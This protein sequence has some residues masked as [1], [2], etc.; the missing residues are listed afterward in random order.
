VSSEV[1]S[2]FIERVKEL[3]TTRAV[4]ALLEWDQET[5]MPPRAAQDRARQ[6]ALLAGLAHAQLTSDELGGLLEQLERQGVGDDWAAKTNLR[7]IRREYER[8]VRL[9]R[10]LVEEIARTSTLA[11]NAWVQARKESRFPG[12]APHLEKLLEL[13]RQAADLIGWQ[14]ERYD[15]LLDEFE[16][17]AQ[18]A[19]IQRIFDAVRSELVPLVAAI[20]QA[21]RQPDRSIRRRHC[22]RDAQE[23]F[24]RRIVAALGFSFEAGRIDVS[25]HPFCTGLS[26]CDVR[27][28]TRY[29][30]QYLPMALFGVLHECGHALYE[31]GLDAAHTWTPMAQSVS[32]GIHESQ[33]R[34]WEN[35]VGRSRAFWQ[36]W[37]P[38]LQQTFPSLADVSL[39][40]WVF[41]INTV[42]PSLIRVE[43]D[44]VTY[45]LHI[46]L[47]FD[48]ERQML[49]GRIAVR[50][51]PQAWNAGMQALLGITPPDDARGCLQDIHW[52]MGIFGYFPT[53]ALGNL[54]A[55]Q[56][57]AAAQR[58]LP[59]LEQQLARGEVGPLREW[60]RQNIHRHGKRY[61]AD[62]LVRLVTGQALSPQPFISYLHAKYR[63]LYGLDT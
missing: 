21:R 59:D 3:N 5:Y 51:I 17:G 25:A 39:D 8:A 27:L 56:F 22:P 15:A 13:K 35:Q 1:Y 32:L 52:S 40:A 54:Y 42:E 12:F 37:F 7:E 45:N 23:A 53:Y 46:M 11:R 48:L 18:A 14:T 31:Q 41:V 16:P 6:V 43:A 61:R 60:L 36:H 28:T 19:R 49:E 57:F 2:R 38:Q 24:N 4:Q 44:E 63:P 47:R 30:E 20:S 29:D 33:S 34:L 55:A 50:D 26:P 58:A 10:S 9:P 62:E